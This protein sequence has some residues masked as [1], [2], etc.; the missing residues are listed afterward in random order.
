MEDILWRMMTFDGRQPLM[1]D[2]FYIVYWFS[3]WNE[4]M[5]VTFQLVYDP[6][7]INV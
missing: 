1:E 5:D 7:F 6:A 4:P 2:E 3:T